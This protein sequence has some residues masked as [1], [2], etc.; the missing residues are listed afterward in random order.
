MR[1]LLGGGGDVDAGG[2]VEGCCVVDSQ[3]HGCFYR[4]LNLVEVWVAALSA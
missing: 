2:G 1:V 3:T 4:V